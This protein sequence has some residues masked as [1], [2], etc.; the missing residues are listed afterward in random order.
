[1]S[2]RRV[3]RGGSNDA[4]STFESRT[5]NPLAEESEGLMINI[6]SVNGDPEELK[7]GN[8]VSQRYQHGQGNTKMGSS[9]LPPY[10]AKENSR[11]YGNRSTNEP[12]HIQK[13][14][15]LTGRAEKQNSSTSI[16]TWAPRAR[17][18][19]SRSSAVLSQDER[20]TFRES[21]SQTN[22][23]YD[24]KRAQLDDVEREILQV[25][26]QIRVLHEEHRILELR[27][28]ELD[29]DIFQKERTTKK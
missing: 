11:S 4:R 20:K 10:S 24:Q 25:N 19:G 6:R 27:S 18:T 28:K 29:E 16:L 23:V 1:M 13:S 14:S 5:G 2:L 8:F 7:I 21:L 12:Q 3:T 15:R 17:S 22:S 26:N 9:E